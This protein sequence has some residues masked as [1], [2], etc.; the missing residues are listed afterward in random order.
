[1]INPITLLA[2]KVEKKLLTDGSKAPIT[3][4]S[5]AVISK[6]GSDT[7]V[8]ILKNLLASTDTQAKLKLST[9]EMVQLREILNLLIITPYG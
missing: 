9:D 2:N 5:V 1:M 7:Y 6:T 4:C 3:D 8:I